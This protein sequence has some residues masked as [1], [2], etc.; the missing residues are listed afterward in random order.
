MPPPTNKVWMRTVIKIWKQDFTGPKAHCVYLNVMPD[1]NF[2]QE[3]HEVVKMCK[4]FLNN[5][6]DALRQQLFFQDKYTTIFLILHR[7][8]LPLMMK[9]PPTTELWLKVKTCVPKKGLNHT[10]AKR[11]IKP[12]LSS[13][14]ILWWTESN[15]S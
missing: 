9:K 12:V 8:I 15:I 4:H 11:L 7:W 1:G 10:T 14:T 13:I 6:S 3:K 5:L 2:V